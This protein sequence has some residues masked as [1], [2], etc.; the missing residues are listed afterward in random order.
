MKLVTRL[1]SAS[2][3]LDAELGTSDLVIG[4]DEEKALAEL[5]RF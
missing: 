1:L 2:L 5:R 4:S 3:E